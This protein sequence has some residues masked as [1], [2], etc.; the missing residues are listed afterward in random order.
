M[1][2]VD[3]SR[4]SLLAFDADREDLLKQLQAFREV[5]FLDLR[6]KE[7]SP[8]VGLLEPDQRVNRIE[9]DLSQL[10]WMLKLLR[11]HDTRPGGL[12]GMQ[13]GLPSYSFDEMTSKAETID[14][15]KDYYELRE[16]QAKLDELAQAKTDRQQDI[17][18][19]KPWEALP[20]HR[21]DLTSLKHVQVHLGVIARKFMDKFQEAFQELELSDYHVINETGGNFYLAVIAHRDENE[22]LQDVLRR[23]GFSPFK[24][25]PEQPVAAEL[26]QL[27]REIA[28]IDQDAKT[29]RDK[30]PDYAPRMADY[31]LV[32]EAKANELVKLGATRNFLKTD[33]LTLVQGY[34]PTE[35]EAEFKQALDRE[36]GDDY[37]VEMSP[38]DRN[39]PDVPIKLKNNKFAESFSSITS[40]YA[41]P[42][43]NEIDPTPFFAPF[44]WMFFGMMGADI[45][46]GLIMFIGTWIAL[47]K[48]N[49][50]PQMRGFIRFFHYLSIS[51]MVWGAIYGSFFGGIIELPGLIDPS[52]D[53][54]TLMIICVA[55]GFLHLMFGLG[56]NAYMIIR[57]GSWKDA[58]Y[59]VGFWYMTLIG[60]ILTLLSVVLKFPPIMLYICGAMFVIGMIGVVA[61]T[62]R[63]S[64]NG[65]VRVLKGLYNLYGISSYVGDFVSYT[66]LM[67]I[68]LAGGF[69]GV[70]VNL[71]TQMLFGNVLGIPLAIIVFLGFHAFNI[72][73]SMLSAYVHTSRLTY[74]E[75]FGKFYSGGGPAFKKFINDSKYITIKEND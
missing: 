5:H 34:V 44:Y 35:M 2:I 72:F 31:E 28:E 64:R 45:G 62:G 29:W 18:A 47:K 67:A 48:F 51:V 13:L 40:M 50:K 1:A 20:Y 69:I 60:G 36:L 37:Y 71:I 66:R 32:Y 55:F 58:F 21:T 22:V 26:D 75:F 38:A 53:I 19:L 16:I 49:L 41:L 11:E 27:T 15:K 7:L 25:E 61:F 3:M 10:E 46:Y 59:D 23:N 74:V 54:I 14:F 57:D 33:R 63:A 70:A 9:E 17:V 8:G 56:L 6:D 73:L 43:Y 24:L 12:K 68:G 4:F 30:L 42:H 39:D 52:A 65:T